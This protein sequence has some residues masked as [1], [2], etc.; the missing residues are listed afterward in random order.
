MCR[1]AKLSPEALKAGY[2]RAYRDFYSW[3]NV[4][5]GAL[6][7][8]SRKHQAKHFFCAGGWK[9][10]EP[11]WDL[12]IKARRLGA[13]TPLLEAL[14]SKVSNRGSAPPAAEVGAPAPPHQPTAR[15]LAG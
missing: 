1:P 9:K 2:D 5:R 15:P 6:S 10:F 7:H 14:L 13:M 8:D 12:A 4:A 11:L 3:A